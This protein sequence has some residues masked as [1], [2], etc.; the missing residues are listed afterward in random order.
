MF[1]LN[2]FEKAK[3]VPRTF[4]VPV[5]GLVDWF[6][7][8]EKQQKTLDSL[9]NGAEREKFIIEEIGAVWK[10]RGLSDDELELAAKDANGNRERLAE[11]MTEMLNLKEGDSESIKEKLGL[12]E[13]VNQQT[14]LRAEHLYRGSVEP[15]INIHVAHKLG[16]AN[17]IEFR[18]LANKILE[19]SGLGAIDEK[20]LKPS[21]KIKKSS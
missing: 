12:N 21:G 13:G 4:D 17:P 2:A 8:T 11:V 1:D 3:L 20:K 6:E 18:M 10:V 14:A 15:V 19:L 9:T 16:Q 7:I 5:P